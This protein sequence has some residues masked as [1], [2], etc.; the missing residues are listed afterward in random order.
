M[1]TDQGLHGS[2][3][4]W[5]LSSI[6]PSLESA[7][8]RDALAQLERELTALDQYLVHSEV[9]RG[10][11]RLPAPQFAEVIAGYLQRANAVMAL[12]WTLSSYVWAF[13]TTDSYDEQAKK[14]YTQL[15]ESGVRLEQCSVRFQG[16]LGEH[17]TE[18]EGAMRAL[19]A[20][21]Q[22]A[23]FLRET[24]DLSRYLMSEAEETLA[25]ELSQS[26]RSAWSRLQ[27]TVVSQLSVVVEGTGGDNPLPIT[28]VLNL[29]RHPDPAVRRSAYEAELE[30]W[31]KAREPLAAALNGVTGAALTLARRRGRPDVLTESIE[32]SRIDRTI[33]DA[34]LGAIDASLPSLRRY[35]QRK[36]ERLGHTALPWWDLFAPLPDG[37]RSFSFDE[38]RE[39][40][41]RHFSEFSPRLGGLAHRAFDERW[42]DAEPRQGKGAGAYCMPMPMVGQSRVFCN[43]AGAFDDVVS[44][45][46]ELGHAFQNECQVGKT[47]LQKQM[48]MTLAETASIF[49]E[50]IVTEA[51]LE[52][53]AG[54]AERLEILEG[55]LT[56]R[57]QILVDVTS[58]F[59]FEREVFE[60]R[61]KAE[62]SA[63]EL[64]D[65][66]SR[67]QA[68]AYGSALDV[69]YR[70]PY[71][72]TWKVH[73][74]RPDVSFYNYPYPFGLLFGLG[75]YA[76][77]RELGEAFLPDYEALLADSG[78]ARAADLAA[79]FGI[80]LRKPEFW[81]A[82]L[83]IIDQQVEQYLAL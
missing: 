59:L 81:Q 27:G 34:M 76:R 45:A 70:H 36:A 72:W 42:I 16:W 17:A 20:L 67:A 74:Y 66:M 30:A 28:E 5:D 11:Q 7:P 13:V 60:R 61:A 71:M 31:E 82:G 44:L 33:L 41:L 54:P 9:A 79:R 12:Y 18:I 83:R 78:E 8:F 63:S 32:R 55:S 10:A 29:A 19:P 3:P 49:N 23:F 4:R 52:A 56:G 53:A 51:A 14:L 58:R 57:T 48:P 65:I 1:T 46:H 37:A 35:L 39:L 64:C 25:A 24:A 69:R 47:E 73:Y 62:L 26:G 75:L 68:V 22:H 80:D 21:Q 50:T 38:S 43:F 15:E 2:L 40:L 6:Y 77:Y